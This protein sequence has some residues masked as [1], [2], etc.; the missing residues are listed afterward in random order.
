MPSDGYSGVAEYYDLF[1]NKD[2]IDFYLTLAM[3]ATSVLDIGAGT[4]RI[5]IPLLQEGINVTCIEP[6]EDM[7]AVFRKKVEDVTIHCDKA[8]AFSLST[9][10]DLCIMSGVF[11]HLLTN[12]ERFKTLDNIANHLL[13]HGR[14]VF[15]VHLGLLM[16]RPMR[17]VDSIKY[18]DRVIER[19]IGST[20]DGPFLR[21]NLKFITYQRDKK[22]DE[23]TVESLVSRSSVEEIENLL[24]R[25]GFGDI[26]L[27]NDYQF[28]PYNQ[29]DSLLVVVTTKLP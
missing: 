21:T 16:E 4:G 11:D 10:F 8:S 24:T 6:S 5:A 13:P 26:S 17:L 3:N 27:Y 28:T 1:D 22:T 23:K 7:I 9:K 25:V 12:E 29:G 18:G 15:D 2:N 19:H 14:L 20:W